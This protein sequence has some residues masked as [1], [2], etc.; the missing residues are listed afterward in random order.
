[1]GLLH[2]RTLYRWSSAVFTGSPPSSLR[3]GLWGFLDGVVVGRLDGQVVVNR[4]VFSVGH[5]VLKMRVVDDD[6]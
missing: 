4:E 1:M 5:C 3:D 2:Y 6:K